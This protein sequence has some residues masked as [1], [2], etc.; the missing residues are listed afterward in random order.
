MLYRKLGRTGLDTSVIS[1]G[2]EHLEKEDRETIKDVVGTAVGNGIN[3]I[4]LIGMVA[5]EARDNMGAALRGIR[6]KVML[7]AHFGATYQNGEYHKTRDT[8]L[9][10]TSFYDLLSRLHTDY[11][12][13]LMF[14][15]VD[16]KMDY[17]EAFDRQGYLGLALRLKQ[18]G[19]VRFL[20]LSTHRTSIAMKA[21]RSG[22]MD[23]I[24]F[25]VNPAHDLLP[26]DIGLEPM[27]Q[28]D[29]YR[30]LSEDAIRPAEKRKE[31]Y[32]ACQESNVGLIAMKPY[33][34]G[35]LLQ[36]GNPSDFLKGRGLLHPG[37]LALSPVQCLSYVL[38]QPGITTALTG[39]R[40]PEEVEAA[41]A[42]VDAGQEQRDFSAIDVN[43]LWKLRRSCVYCN[44]CLPC[45]SEIEIGSLM[46]LLDAAEHNLNEKVTAD[47]RALT[48]N[49]SD[50]TYCGICT[51]RCPF[52]VAVL[53]R[54]ERAIKVFGC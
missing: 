36:D 26:G 2:A 50:C 32:L 15:W 41:I 51:E 53:D 49:A 31:L 44:H 7:S 1:L 3:L 22:F 27:W 46:R 4:D 52:D 54:M 18:E 28:K 5:P 48:K 38:S 35:L 12:D 16:E 23:A 20:A 43:S 9:C 8:S 33:A 10:E 30:Q 25:P 42:Y 21:M 45:P 47:Y 13:I 40:K 39:C 37:R 24:M 6:E 19:K 14:H 34:G 29:T 17:E 11:I